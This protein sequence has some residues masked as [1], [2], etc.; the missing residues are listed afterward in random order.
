VPEVVVDGVTGILCD[1][2][3]ELA[4]AITAVRDLSPAACRAHVENCFDAASM[5][6]G[7][8]AVYRERLLP[9]LSNEVL[10][11]S[12]RRTRRAPTPAAA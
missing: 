7:Y 3:A 6:G 5:V 4:A 11:R 1:D 12:G 8:E 2:P 9:R 10:V